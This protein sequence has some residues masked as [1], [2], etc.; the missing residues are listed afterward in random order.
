MAG[1]RDNVHLK[2]SE[3]ALFSDRSSAGSV[4]AAGAGTSLASIKNGG[5]VGT[6]PLVSRLRLEYESGATVALT[7]PVAVWVEENSILHKAAE[8]NGGADI[9]MASGQGYVEILHFILLYDYIEIVAAGHSG[10]N[11]NGY[12]QVVAGY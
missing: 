8:L 12:I 6:A 7:G 1:L 9:S 10:G 5:G 4:P 3:L 2:G 11:Y